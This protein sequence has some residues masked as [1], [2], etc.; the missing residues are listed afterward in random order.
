MV[1][2]EAKNDNSQAETPAS[3]AASAAR[4]QIRFPSRSRA[5]N[6]YTESQRPSDLSLPPSQR[7]AQSLASPTAHVQQASAAQPPTLAEDVALDIF[8][9]DTQLQLHLQTDLPAQSGLPSSDKLQQTS[10]WLSHSQC[11]LGVRFSTHL[12]LL[13]TV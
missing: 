10:G 1:T 5:L 4:L 9:T 13:T 12:P 2:A 11:N 3:P 6:S 8:A 7:A